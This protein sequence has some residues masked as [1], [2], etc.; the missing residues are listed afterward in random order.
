MDAIK[1][2][3]FVALFIPWLIFSQKENGTLYPKDTIYIQY[4]H[5]QQNND[6]NAK[7]K[8]NYRGEFGI[9]FNIESSSGDIALFYS[10][11]KKADTLC[12][13]Y[14]NNFHLSSLEEINEKRNEWIFNNKRPPAD[15]NGVFQTYVVE[16]ISNNKFVKYPVIW[17]NEGKY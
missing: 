17:R 14:L 15:R 3:A 4:V 7:F 8:R 6:W 10:F 13:E 9:F 5:T 2:T 1:K 11:K 12:I 16:I